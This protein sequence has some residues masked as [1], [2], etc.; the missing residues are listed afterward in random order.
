MGERLTSTVI[1]RGRSVSAVHFPATYRYFYAY[2]NAWWKNSSVL[3]RIDYQQNELLPPRGR[4]DSNI[5]RVRD[6]YLLRND[7]ETAS[8]K[9]ITR[10]R[11]GGGPSSIL[12]GTRVHRSTSAELIE[13]TSPPRLYS[14]AIFPREA[15]PV[16]GASI[17]SVSRR[18]VSREETE[19]PRRQGT[20]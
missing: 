11:R 1:K 10:N 6:R 17:S 20:R 2:I 5:C 12:R 19:E 3:H 13:R 14:P 7:F 9:F 18:N 15:R 8:D 16:L 4:T